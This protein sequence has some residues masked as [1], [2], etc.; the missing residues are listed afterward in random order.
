MY[1]AYASAMVHSWVHKQKAA[2]EVIITTVIITTRKILFLF[3]PRKA[4]MRRHKRE[5]NLLHRMVRDFF[6]PVA[7]DIPEF[8]RNSTLP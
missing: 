6:I 3:K 5:V 8:S 4:I 1:T 2:P 7:D